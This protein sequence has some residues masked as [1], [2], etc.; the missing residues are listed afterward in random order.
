MP[1]CGAPPAALAGAGALYA[2]VIWAHKALR[3]DLLRALLRGFKAVAAGAGGAPAADPGQLGFAAAL[4]AA[5]PLRRG[6]EACLVLAEA[7]AVI[8]RH[9][10]DAAHELRA[11]VKGKQ[12]RKFLVAFC[13]CFYFLFSK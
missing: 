11:V 9:G 10:E 7:D 4:L 12:V 1:S 3:A 8:S 13:F 5:L 6:D 2:D